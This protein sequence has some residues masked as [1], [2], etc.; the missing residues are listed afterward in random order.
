MCGRFTAAAPPELIAEAFDLSELPNLEPRYN[1]APTQEVPVVRDLPQGGGRRLDLLRWGLIPYG[2]DPTAP[3]GAGVLINA[4]AE[5]V[6]EKPSFRTAFLRR[7]CLVVSDGFYEWKRLPGG[8]QPYYL[9]LRSGRPFGFAGLWDRWEP[10][11]REPVE[12]CTI[13]TTEPN[14]LVRPIHDRM[15]VILGPDAYDLWLDPTPGR[16]ARLKGLL[17][18]FGDDEMVAFPVSPLVNRTEND[19]PECIEALRD[20]PAAPEAPQAEQG[21]LFS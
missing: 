7:R 14:S 10:E 17:R 1:I 21:E 11:D 2:T 3:A 19:S 20:A 16:T 15:P 6:D 9:K 13:L 18:P 8:K 4:R 12:S 5:T